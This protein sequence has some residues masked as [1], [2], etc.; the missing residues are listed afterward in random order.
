M[1]EIAIWARYHQYWLSLRS[2]GLHV[3]IIRYEDIINNP[4]STTS[5][6]FNVLLPTAP[7]GFT[8]RFSS[9]TDLL[10]AVASEGQGYKPRKSR[11][12]CICESLQSQYTA[13]QVEKM[14]EIAQSTM[15]A[16]GYHVR[17]R[18]DNL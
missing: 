8:P 12:S 7:I 1:N 9:A 4:E 18:K 10:Q 17:Q 3:H 5:H 13:E 15:L 16:L 2:S 6:M 14:L 11:T